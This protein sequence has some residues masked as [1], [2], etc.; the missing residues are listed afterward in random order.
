M[1]T[2]SSFHPVRKSSSG[3][4]GWAI[5]IAGCL[6]ACTSAMCQTTPPVGATSGF[7]AG[8]SANEVTK[9]SA[10][11]KN[12]RGNVIIVTREDGTECM[13]QFPDDI[14]SMSFIAK[15][16]PGLLRQ[17]TPVRFAMAIGPNGAAIS[18]VEKIEIFAPLA[19][20]T[21]PHNQA[22][23]FTPGVHHAGQQPGQP[24]PPAAAGGGRVD[25]VGTLM[26]VTP[27][28]GLAVQ[29]GA[30]PVNTMVTPDAEIEVQMN[31]LSLAQAGDE[32]E[33]E[34]FYN[35]PD[36]TKVKAQRITITTDR[37]IGEMA[38]RKQRVRPAKGAKASPAQQDPAAPTNEKP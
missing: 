23:R 36:E 2:R 6:A 35:P 31:N 21:V 12:A 24:I 37:V 10:T 14:T 32:V 16:A 26:M 18:P 20:A 38:A 22:V 8:T 33:V 25:V 7:A 3:A 5:A 15:A 13:V 4:A 29:A 19:P 34:G 9:F 27:Q 1:R 30:T 17:G 11:L 28:G